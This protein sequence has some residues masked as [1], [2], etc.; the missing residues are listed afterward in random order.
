MAEIAGVD[1][2]CLTAWSQR[3]TGLVL[4]RGAHYGARTARQRTSRRALERARLA[5]MAAHIDKAA[6]TRAEMLADGP[7]EP[8]AGGAL[9]A[10]PKFLDCT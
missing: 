10:R 6:F 4:D 9:V 7:L 3:S 2:D 1:K 8:G 5:A